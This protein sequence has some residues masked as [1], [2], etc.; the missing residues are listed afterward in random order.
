MDA[1]TKRADLAAR[2]KSSSHLTDMSEELKI[3]TRIMRDVYFWTTE[4]NMSPPQ[5]HLSQESNVKQA[6]LS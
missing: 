4:M 3:Y 1:D 6:F 2:I 5:S